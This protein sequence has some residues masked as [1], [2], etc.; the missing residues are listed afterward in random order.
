[1]RHPRRVCF[2]AVSDPVVRERIVRGVRAHGYSPPALTGLVF[3]QW[4][5]DGTADRLSEEIR[6]ECRARLAMAQRIL[7]STMEV[8]DEAQSP[9]VWLPM[10]ELQAERVAGR[11][12]RAGVEVTPPDAPGVG[13]DAEA[14]VR[15]CLGAVP[16]RAVLERAL[17]VVLAS[18]EREVDEQSRAVI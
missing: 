16:D 15:L 9:H 8:P 5:A 10:T 14:G 7:G 18:L 2:L 3:A 17:H 13:D 4:H 1:M 6:E 12:L 11:A